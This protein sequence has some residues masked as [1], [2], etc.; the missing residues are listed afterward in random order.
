MEMATERTRLFVDG[1]RTAITAQV[2]G[3]RAGGLVV[4]QALPFLR[5]GTS[6]LE[7]RGKRGRIARVAIA[8]DGDV[9]QLLLE[10][11][12]EEVECAMP[13]TIEPPREEPTVETFTPGVS[14][15]P[16]RTD[17]TVP[18]DYQ[19]GEKSGPIVLA[20]D[21]RLAEPWWMRAFRKIGALVAAMF[22]QAPPRPTVAAPEPEP[23]S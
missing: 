21:I 14:M 11:E 16:A 6:V 7:D 18:Y 9:P 1:V 5:M 22:A 23:G 2:A 4:T 19:R 20:D 17:S 3:R 15:R 8:M 13:A 10:L 12:D